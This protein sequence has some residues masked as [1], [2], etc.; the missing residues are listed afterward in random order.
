MMD[1]DANHV[2]VNK[3]IVNIINV[4]DVPLYYILNEN[5]YD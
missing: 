1:V 2:V 5:E 4:D 3:M